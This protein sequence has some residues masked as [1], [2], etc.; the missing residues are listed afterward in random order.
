M[1]DSIMKTETVKLTQIKVNGANPR[2]IKDD[3]FEKLVNSTNVEI[4]DFQLVG[5]S[6]TIREL[7]ILK[8]DIENYYP[9]ISSESSM[10]GYELIEEKMSAKY[11]TDW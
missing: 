7:Y 5:R 11:R 1:G 3:K 8:S 6:N 10:V 9:V 4:V 2:I